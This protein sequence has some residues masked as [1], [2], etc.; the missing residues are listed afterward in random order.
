MFLICAVW[1]ERCKQ[2]LKKWRALPTE[3]KNPYLSQA[4]DNRAAI[5]MKKTQQVINICIYVS[6]NEKKNADFNYRISFY[7]LIK[8]PQ[9]RFITKKRDNLLG[10]PY[11]WIFYWDFCLRTCLVS[12]I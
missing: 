4:R 5:R 3:K 2:I 11:F 1:S 12:N 7:A 6:H 8:H 10:Y 9:Q